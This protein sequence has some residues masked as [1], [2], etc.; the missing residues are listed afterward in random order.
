[1][2]NTMKASWGTAVRAAIVAVVTTAGLAIVCVP[3]HADESVLRVTVTDRPG[4]PGEALQQLERQ[5][6]W[7]TGTP[8]RA[9]AVDTAGQSLTVDQYAALVSGREVEGVQVL[10][11]MR[12]GQELLDT[13]MADLSDGSYDGPHDSGTSTATLLFASPIPESRDWCLTMCLAS[14]KRHE[15]ILVA[16]R[17]AGW[18]V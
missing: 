2:R 15:C 9:V 13:T 5:A 8:D 1:M 17:N 12:G 18:P 4:A 6:G 14:L 3:S 7:P 16:M 10:G 11:V